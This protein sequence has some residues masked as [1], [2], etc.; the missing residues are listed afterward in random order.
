M[1]NPIKYFMYYFIFEIP[2]IARPLPLIFC[3][4]NQYIKDF[5]ILRLL[6]YVTFPLTMTVYWKN[7]K[8]WEIKLKMSC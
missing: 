6:Y 5:I 7:M 3:K 4:I 1:K 2:Y 8:K